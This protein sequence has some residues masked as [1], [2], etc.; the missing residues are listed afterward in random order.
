MTKVAIISDTH[1]G[2]RG[3][4]INFINMT[5][6]FL[7]N[8]FFPTLKE[9]NIS[10]IIH[11]GDLVDRRKQVNILT[12]KR[13]REDY[14]EPIH[15]Y[16]FE[17]HQILGNHDTYHKN[18]NNVN[19]VQ[20]LCGDNVHWYDTATEI[21][22]NG[23]NIL[24]VPWICSE[25]KDHSYSMIT[26]S[27]ASLCLGHLELVGFEM[28]KG[29]VATHGDSR[30]LF[31]KFELT[32]S[33]HYHHKS[34][35]GSIHY[36]GSHG[37]F[38]WSDYGDERG[39]HI[40]DLNTKELT[41]IQNPYIMFTKVHYN[42]LEKSLD[43]LLSFDFNHCKNTYVK[44]IVKNKTNP[45]WFDKFCEQIEKVNVIDMQIVDDHLNLNIENDSDI[46]NEAESTLDIFKKH[47]GK[48]SQ[49]NLNKNKLETLVVDLYNQALTVE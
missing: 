46:V 20:E 10:H 14:L 7:D 1:Y 44:V 15:N 43:D 19:A 11:L 45:Y 47:I 24:L 48:I 6:S 4:N 41:F 42:D 30:D 9:Q 23:V 34:S 28:Y 3:D 13:M 12:A 27:K 5:K 17:Y 8:I 2:V 21:Q 18:T 29:S 38:T 16:G 33:G 37:Q 25:N 26:Q 35:D 32:L 22:I 31:D 40:L 36:V 39:F 49:T